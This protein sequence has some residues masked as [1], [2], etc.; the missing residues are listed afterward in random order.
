MLILHNKT[1]MTKS[2]VTLPNEKYKFN[3]LTQ[4]TYAPLVKILN[5]KGPSLL[6]VL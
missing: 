1:I 3:N 5:T 6:G 4:S 2:Q